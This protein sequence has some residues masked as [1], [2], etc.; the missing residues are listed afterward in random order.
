MG[1]GECNSY[2]D[3]NMLYLCLFLGRGL[4]GLKMIMLILK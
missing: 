1:I 3:E 2:K 4:Y